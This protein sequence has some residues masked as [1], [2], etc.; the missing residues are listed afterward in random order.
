[1]KTKKKKLNGIVLESGLGKIVPV[2]GIQHGPTHDWMEKVYRFHHSTDQKRE[3]KDR[4]H[5]GGSPIHAVLMVGGELEDPRTGAAIQYAYINWP[6]DTTVLRVFELE[7]GTLWEEMTDT[8][9]MSIDPGQPIVR[10]QRWEDCWLLRNK[11]DQ[12]RKLIG[13]HV[14]MLHFLEPLSER[15]MRLHEARLPRKKRK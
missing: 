13:P 8:T 7:D 4:P 2:A 10:D 5:Y 6:G 15:G 9:P 3:G 14:K 1:M 11:A 12:C